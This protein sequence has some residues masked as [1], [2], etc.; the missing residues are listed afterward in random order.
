VPEKASRRLKTFVNTSG[1]GFA[2]SSGPCQACQC[3]VSAANAVKYKPLSTV[4]ADAV[5]HQRAQPSTAGSL[6][7]VIE[8][9]NVGGGNASA[10]VTGKTSM[11]GR[12]GAC[13]LQCVSSKSVPRSSNG[14]GAPTRQPAMRDNY[15]MGEW[16]D[17]TGFV[18][19]EV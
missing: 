19:Q 8:G 16:K 13:L 12:M 5:S 14:R 7:S 10:S 6:Q 4:V 15:L 18:I 11:S 9:Q 17:L 2:L 3:D 1:W